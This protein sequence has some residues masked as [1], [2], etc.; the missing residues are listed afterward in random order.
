MDDEYIKFETGFLTP[1][2]I[3]L[4]F[5]NLPVDITFVDNEGL[6]KYFSQAKERIFARTKAVIGRNL[7]NCHL[8]A[9][10]HIVEELLEDFKLGKKDHEDFWLRLGDKFVLI[11]C[12]LFKVGT[13]QYVKLLQT[14]T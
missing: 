5:N 9:S 8:P 3:L 14:I 12:F 6:V 10:V 13:F 7:H 1:K 11:Q 2:Q 4:M